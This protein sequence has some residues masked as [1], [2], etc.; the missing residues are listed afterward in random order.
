MHKNMRGFATN[1][2]HIVMTV[3]SQRGNDLLFIISSSSVF[4]K[5]TMDTLVIGGNLLRAN[6]DLVFVRLVSLK[7]DTNLKL[8]DVLD[9]L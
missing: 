5:L 9:K 7:S 1:L 8:N 2:E 6:L 4:M 3:I